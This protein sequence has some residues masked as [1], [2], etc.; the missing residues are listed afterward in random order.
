[1]FQPCW[2]HEPNLGGMLGYLRIG[3]N[4]L[5]Q[6]FRNTAPHRRHG[7]FADP[8]NSIDLSHIAIVG[9]FL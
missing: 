3:T 5:S 6:T 8:P 1:M 4:Q 2:V 9:A 7:G